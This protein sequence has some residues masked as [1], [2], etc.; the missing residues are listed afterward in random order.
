MNFTKIFSLLSLLAFL[1]LNQSSAQNGNIEPLE[2]SV[3]KLQIFIDPRMEL[4]TT[5]Q[6]IS[7]YPMVD[8]NMSYSKDVIKYFKSFKTQK[9]VKMTNQLLKEHGFCYDAPVAL[10]LYLSQLPELK[11]N[12]PYSDY[13]IGRSGGRNNLEQYRKNIKEFS[14]KS[15]F[16]A[17]WNSKIP[18]YNQI[19]DMTIVDMGDKDLVKVLEEYFNETQGSYNIII[20]PAFIGG[21]GPKVTDNNGRENI[22]ACL[23]TTSVKE[24]IPYLSNLGLILYVWHEFGHSFVNPLSEKYAEKVSSSEKLFEPIK[25][26]MA[27]QAYSSWETCVNEHVIRAVNVRL[28]EL[29]LDEEK[30]KALLNNELSRSFIYIEPLIEKLKEFEKQRDE[31]QITFSDFYPEILS[32][33]DSLQKIEYWKE[34]NVIFTGPINA[35]NNAEKIVYIY[36]TQDNDKKGLKI[37][38]DYA[39]K[40]YNMFAKPKGG[41][42][43]ADTTALKT[44]LTEYGITAYGTIES[45]LFLKQHAASFP[46]RIENQTIYADQEYT[47]KNTKLITCLPNPFNPEKGMNIYTAL[48]NKSIKGINSVFH[49]REDYILFL[50]Q[51]YIIKNGK[52]DK[53]EKWE[54]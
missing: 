44:D 42:W 3:G 32:L 21:Y 34:V 36:P 24:G 31:K 43:M 7:N 10:M 18:F 38:Q 25:S 12:I 53:N 37:A 22:Y 40:M 50:N 39:F 51:S 28:Y 4:L 30:S 8:R 15:N 26:R 20:S 13:L 9:A 52:Y 5:I 49:G 11:L 41:L 19:L 2:R 16:A 45:N 33:L 29:H 46:F 23:T 54:F 35:V 17:F 1:F 27:R 48:S 14:E 6:L 47:D